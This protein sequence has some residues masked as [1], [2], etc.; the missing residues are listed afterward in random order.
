MDRAL[1][2]ETTF[3]G[4]VNRAEVLSKLAGLGSDPG[5]ATRALPEAGV[6][7]GFVIVRPLDEA[8][9]ME[10]ARLRP[11]TCAAGL[12]FGDRACLALA[13]S[14]DLPAL[15]ADRARAELNLG[16]RVDLIR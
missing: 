12:S 10:I 6:S 3:V 9:A 1:E 13:A 11:L 15:T 5:S 4:A 16:M 7:G 14:L 8:Q 2:S